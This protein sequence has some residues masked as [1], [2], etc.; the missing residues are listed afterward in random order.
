VAQL[1]VKSDEELENLHRQISNLSDEN[2]ELRN[3]FNNKNAAF[4]DLSSE[5]SGL[6]EI[7]ETA[8]TELKH[9]EQQ[10]ANSVLQLK[11]TEVQ[12]DC[13]LGKT[14][15]LQVKVND[16]EEEVVKE[17][18]RATELERRLRSP[19]SMSFEEIDSI[20]SGSPD[21][22]PPIYVPNRMFCDHCD[23]FDEHDT[24]DC[25]EGN[26]PGGVKHSGGAGLSQRPYCTVCE[27][28][29]HTAVDCEDEMTF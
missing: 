9:N 13:A 2:E 17:R 3:A 24:D 18:S 6:R 25:I 27:M 26:S 15:E 20:E 1:S 19:P 28:F 29:G 22:T 12:L 11:S 4:D 21:I 10:F 14:R 23:L 5:V 16:L 7:S 8:F